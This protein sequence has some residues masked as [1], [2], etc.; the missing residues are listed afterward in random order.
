MLA[1]KVGFSL[2]MVKRQRTIHFKAKIH[3]KDNT[4]KNIYKTAWSN[5]QK[6]KQ[7]DIQKEIG[8]LIINKF[9]LAQVKSMV[10]Q[11]NIDLKQMIPKV[12]HKD[13]NKNSIF[14]LKTQWPLFKYIWN[15]PE[16]WPY[17]RKSQ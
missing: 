12:G 3:N 4:A 6:W 7:K 1:D 16:N 15:I 8:W 14:Q 17:I 11:V 2:R 10:G 13:K 5:I 9:I